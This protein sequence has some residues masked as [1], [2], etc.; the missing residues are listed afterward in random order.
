MNKNSDKILV[1]GGSG[2]VGKE[3][4]SQLL[5]NGYRVRAIKHHSEIK[6]KS[7]N[8]EIVEGDLLDVISLE[9][10]MKGITFVFHCAA[11]VSYD[12][13]DRYRL[14]KY[15]IE[16][17]ANLVNAC[18][19]ASIQKLVHVSSVAA[20]GRLEKDD[21]E[22]LVTEKTPWTEKNS[23]SNYGKSKFLSEMEVWRGAG[24]GLNV[25]IVNPS[26]IL[27]GDNWDNGSSAIFK[28]AYNEIP[29]YSDGVSG[30]VD[31]Q[32]VAGAMILLIESDIRSERFILSSENLSFR[33]IFSSIAKCFGKKPPNRRVNK[34]LAEIV[35]RLEK[36][37]A[38]LSGKRPLLTK[39]TAKSS[40]GKVYF[41]NSK[42]LK[43]LPGFTF[44]PIHETIERTC[45]A[46]EEKY[47]LQKK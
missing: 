38:I 5:D 43:A 34:F 44:T 20:I 39:E 25:V 12:P 28:S 19:D 6:V 21:H 45:R 24:E 9:E 14:L 26:L 7:P 42:I 46:M 27:G 1:T 36:V 47:R 29:W 17:T 15:N 35:W 31:V 10:A 3:L 18:I 13:A 2:L 33:E 23:N 37:K 30:F 11:I 40:L 41:D 22:K 32:D 8:L 16:G 4:L